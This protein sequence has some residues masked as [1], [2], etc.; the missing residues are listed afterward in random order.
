MGLTITREDWT[1]CAYPI[2]MG[3]IAAFVA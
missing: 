1:G 2:F 3:S